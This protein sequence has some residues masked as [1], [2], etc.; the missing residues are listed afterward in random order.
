[1][2]LFQKETSVT[3]ENESLDDGEKLR[4]NQRT[5]G[6]VGTK[7]TAVGQGQVNVGISLF[8]VFWPTSV[9]GEG[10]NQARSCRTGEAHGRNFRS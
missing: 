8:L 4:S 2:T 1:M 10:G 7:A 6:D 3:R 9:A 5:G